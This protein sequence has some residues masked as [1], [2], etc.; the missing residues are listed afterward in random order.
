MA[1]FSLA[2]IRTALGQ[3]PEAGDEVVR[4]NGIQFDS[5]QAA[6]GELFVAVSTATGDGNRYVGAAFDGGAQ[7]AIVERIDP[8]QPAGRQVLVADSL[9]ALAALG[10]HFRD[11]A[12]ATVIGV[13][14]SNGKTSTKE[15]MAAALATS[16]SV[17]RSQRSFNN[18]LGVPVT[19]AE[20]GP[21]T[22]FAVVELGAQVVGEIAGYCEIAQ[23]EHGV[24]TN[25]GRAHVGLF[26]S[27]ENVARAKGE[28]GEYLGVE[29]VLALNADDPASAAIA[30]RSRAR[31]VSFGGEGVTAQV[32]TAPDFSGQ[33][34]RIEAGADSGEV[35]IAAIGGH[36]GE[37]FAAAVALGLGLGLDFGRLLEGLGQFQPMP[38]R[39][40]VHEFGG[41]V[42]LD[43]T[44]NANRES[45]RYALGEMRRTRPAGRRLAVLGEMLELGKF[46]PTDHAAVGR[47]AGFL[48]GLATIG[49]DAEI[50]GRE[51]VAAGLDAGSW[52]HFPAGLESLEASRDGVAAVTEWL[53]EELR[54]GDLVLVKG[55][56]ALGLTRVIEALVPGN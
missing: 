53:R 44:Y 4:L 27:P 28:L 43:D 56:N 38:H 55:S 48:D 35:R 36:L 37:S 22:D 25:V 21:E 52:R 20:I 54:D 7:A 11:R 8:G 32:E 50:V 13:T 39:M 14:G 34:V 5:R 12:T 15:A 1:E 24:I 45:C 2:E 51:A 6:P 26:G 23:P 19:L 17:V 47:E 29:G 41:A 3:S 9:A 10:R 40:Q 33:T 42:V 31:I 46:S 49:T 30:A 16:G 18:E